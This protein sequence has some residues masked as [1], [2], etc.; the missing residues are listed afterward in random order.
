M[1]L[2]NK[3]REKTGLAVGIVAVGLGLFVVGG[4][5]IGPNSVLLGKGKRTVGEIGGEEISLEEFD[6]EINQMKQQFASRNR[7]QPNDAENYTIQ[8][9]AWQLL[10]SRYTYDEQYKELGIGVTDSEVVDMVQG[11]NILPEIK[12]GFTNPETGEFDKE[13]LINF[14]N[15]PQGQFMANY[16]QTLRPSRLRLKYE[17]MILNGDYT[18][19]IE[20]QKEYNN[21]TELIDTRYLYVPYS[22]LA[23]SV[24]KVSEGEA[25]AYLNS[26]AED[27]QVNEEGR[28]AKYVDFAVIPTAEDSAAFMKEMAEVK[29]DFRQAKEDSIYAKINTENSRGFNFYG[30]FG[31]AE[32]P[33]RLQINAPILSAGDVRGPYKTGQYYTLYK[34]TDIT[35]GENASVRASHILFKTDGSNDAEV[36]K[37]A[38]KVLK[39]IRGGANFAAMAAKYGQDGTATRG[40]DLGWFTKGRMVA[41]FEKAVFD[42][43]RTGVL[44]NLVKTEFGYHII[45]VTSLPNYNVYTVA[46][47]ERELYPS[48]ESVDAVYKK[49]DLFAS[50]STDYDDFKANAEKDGYA[51]RD[52]VDV[53]ATDRRIGFVGDA[54][55]AVTWLYREGEVGKVSQVFEAGDDHYLVMI[56]TGKTEE[57]TASFASVKSTAERKARNEK[58]AVFIT[59]K[60]Q[61]T[62][63]GDINEWAIAF[64]S[65][66]NVFNKSG[67]KPSDNTL[68]STGF[69]PELVGTALG[70]K[71]GQISGPIKLDNGIAV[72]Q[73]IRKQAAPEIADYNS[74]KD[75][76]NSRKRSQTAF[77]ISKSLEK[78]A[79]VKD[80]RYKHY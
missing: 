53:R 24:F 7:R 60:L 40:G 25:K 44:R 23:D 28:S 10:V 75:Q 61:K 34:V 36:K 12:Q 30:H 27:F 52:A 77:N 57:G 63:N 78:H 46:T 54:R 66:A 64:G 8:N 79:G 14:L 41:P 51:I 33:R 76:L 1:A 39:E 38:Q 56:M 9:Q 45:D 3:I 20:A 69:A 62:K 4:D 18:T 50:T 35:K 49:A 68:P 71:E 42:A 11:E 19:K 74:Y 21:Q 43:K 13:A 26:H 73:V 31:A 67:L 29:E 22:A 16:E 47:I 48:D 32:L 2:I 15:S 65:E 59:E 5:L 72:I 58:K 70:L 55:S 6:A 80:E 17:N 37:E